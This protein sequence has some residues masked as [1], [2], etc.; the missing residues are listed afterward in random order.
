MNTT[1]MLGEAVGIQSQGVLDQTETQ[2][3]LGL[4]SAIIIGQFK[5]GRVDRPMTIHN[6]NI[7]GQLGHE[8]NNPYYNAVQD[9][10]DTGVPSVQ[11][12]RIGGI[13]NGNVPIGCAGAISHLPLSGQGAELTL[14]FIVNDQ[15]AGRIDG[16]LNILAINEILSPYGLC[17]IDNVGIVN[18]S[19]QFVRLRVIAGSFDENTNEV[20]GYYNFWTLPTLANPTVS[21]GKILPD[22]DQ[23][24]S[25][26]AQVYDEDSHTPLYAEVSA[27][28]APS[29]SAISCDGATDNV[30]FTISFPL[31]D[32]LSLISYDPFGYVGVNDFKIDG[33]NVPTNSLPFSWDF[34]LLYNGSENI[35]EQANG[36]RVKLINDIGPNKRIEFARPQGLYFDWDS[37]PTLQ[38][39]ENTN[40][41]TCCL[42]HSV[43]APNQISCDGATL[44]IGIL[45]EYLSMHTPDVLWRIEI[46]DATTGL[47]YSSCTNN[48]IDENSPNLA[49]TLNMNKQNEALTYSLSVENDALIIKNATSN[50]IKLKVIANGHSDDGAYGIEITDIESSNPTAFFVKNIQY[51]YDLRACLSP[52]QIPIGCDGATTTCITAGFER[53][54]Q[55]IVND[56]VLSNDVWGLGGGESALASLLSSVGITYTSSYGRAEFI[57]NTNEFKSIRFNASVYIGPNAEN[58]NPTLHAVDDV[59]T[60]FCLAPA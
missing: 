28:L 1:K 17:F 16:G 24:I 3:N 21:V 56:Q 29:N 60:A 35:S 44:E 6:A 36:A 8:P 38:W 41:V 42:A 18:L 12:L 22:Y 13:E 50:S 33:V 31:T 19:N 57:N 23:P 58:T 59:W 39:D 37:N 47:L 40:L 27:C 4:T 30:G 15:I 46:Y 52:Q 45:F 32:N 43:P 14:L 48:D 20:L 10:L 9:C 53:I 55:L 26:E 2:T 25:V 7:R 11:V 34:V 49:E 5:R 54:W 51:D